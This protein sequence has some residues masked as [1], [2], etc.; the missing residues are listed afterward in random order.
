MAN[1]SQM[2]AAFVFITAVFFVFASLYT[3]T[4]ANTL[5]TGAK[6]PDSFNKTNEYGLYLQNQSNNFQTQV[7][8]QGANPNPLLVGTLILSA[9]S[10]AVISI[11]SIGTIGM[12]LIN[13][14][15]GLL[16][17]PPLLIGLLVTW[18]TYK[19]VAQV[20]RGIRLGDM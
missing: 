18:M 10:T 9:G 3:D 20:V 2:F 17:I 4:H 7:Q 14:F 19:L 13:D 11:L 6:I 12:A 16:S 1:I 5:Y 8:A 15:G